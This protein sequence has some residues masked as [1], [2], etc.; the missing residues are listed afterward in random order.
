MYTNT[1]FKYSTAKQLMIMEEND[2]MKFVKPIEPKKNVQ[3]L[4]L[5]RHYSSRLVLPFVF[6]MLTRYACDEKEPFVP[7]AGQPT[8]SVCP[9]QG[10]SLNLPPSPGKR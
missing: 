4:Q 5:A 10:H 7:S 9:V 8:P 6:Y 3:K 1:T 2:K